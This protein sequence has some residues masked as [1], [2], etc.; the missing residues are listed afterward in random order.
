MSN[1]KGNNGKKLLAAE[2][3]S[4]DQLENQGVNGKWTV[5]YHFV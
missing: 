3:H 2:L 4:T 1:S 5:K